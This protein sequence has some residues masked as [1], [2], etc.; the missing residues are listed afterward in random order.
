[1][2]CLVPTGT[3]DGGGPV[4]PLRAFS[5]SALLRETLALRSRGAEVRTVA[6]DPASARVMGLNLM[7][8]SRAEEVLDVA[9]AQG[10]ALATG[11]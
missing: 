10:R 6:P 2:L 3:L 8:R 7:N 11:R 4:S 1:V 9:F 5:G